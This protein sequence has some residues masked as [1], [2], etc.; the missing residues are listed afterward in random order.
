VA[1]WL[2][3]NYKITYKNVE[4]SNNGEVNP[5]NFSITNYPR[6]E[7]ITKRGYTFTGW[8][9]VLDVNL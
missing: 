8:T 3:N 2:A 7:T 4:G 9:D 6:I 5:S 1:N